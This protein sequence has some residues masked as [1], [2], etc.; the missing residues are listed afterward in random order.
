L[1]LRRSEFIVVVGGRVGLR[2]VGI[3]YRSD[4]GDGCST[5]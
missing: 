2:N 5:F 4:K 1:E 3:S